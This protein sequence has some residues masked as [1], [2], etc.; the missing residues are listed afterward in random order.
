MHSP[1]VW[2]RVPLCILFTLL[3]V[4]QEQPKLRP[5]MRSQ[6]EMLMDKLHWLNDCVRMRVGAVAFVR[7]ISHRRAYVARG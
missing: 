1:S 5:I 4:T 7:L 6:Q 3:L 2:L